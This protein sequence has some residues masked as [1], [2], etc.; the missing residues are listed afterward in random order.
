MTL[1]P[2]PHTTTWYEAKTVE[3]R[4]AIGE[5]KGAYLSAAFQ[6]KHEKVLR[7]MDSLSEAFEIASGAAKAAAAMVSMAGAVMS[8]IQYLPDR[9]AVV[10]SRVETEELR[11][12]WDFHRRPKHFRFKRRFDEEGA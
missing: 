12:R 2:K 8:P 4:K 10:R 9:R 3:L 5:A 1:K 11:N 7:R 6:V